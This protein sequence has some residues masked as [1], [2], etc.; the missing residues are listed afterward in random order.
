MTILGEA[1]VHQELMLEEEIYLSVCTS[2]SIKNQP[3]S[4]L[5]AQSL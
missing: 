1:K 3:L 2:L 5:Q 4:L